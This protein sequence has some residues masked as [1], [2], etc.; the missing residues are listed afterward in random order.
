VSIWATAKV[1]QRIPEEMRSAAMDERVNKLDQ[2]FLE[3][4]TLDPPVFDQL[5]ARASP[6]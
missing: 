2:Q 4:G 1:Q 3:D 6:K 5:P